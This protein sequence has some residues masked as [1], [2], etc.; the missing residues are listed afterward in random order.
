MDVPRLRAGGGTGG[1]HPWV[2]R[3]VISPGAEPGTMDGS[4]L[5]PLGTAGCEEGAPE[6]AAPAAWPGRALGALAAK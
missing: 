5:Q 1:Q 4:L 2:P 3:A 6:P